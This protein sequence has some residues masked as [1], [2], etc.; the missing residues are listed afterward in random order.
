MLSTLALHRNSWFT[1]LLLTCAAFSGAAAL[2]YQVVW[3]RQFLLLFG[4]TTAATAAVIAA[5]MGGMALGAFWLGRY[6][7]RLS[8]PLL[9]YAGLE[10][11]VALYALIF[12]GLLTKAELLYGSV[13]QLVENHP[14]LIN[15]LRL[16]FGLVMLLPPTIALGA[17][18]PLLV[19]IL[20]ARRARPNASGRLDLWDQCWWRCVWSFYRRIIPHSSRGSH[21][22]LS[23]RYWTQLDS[24]YSG[25]GAMAMARNAEIRNAKST[26]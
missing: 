20:A 23:N 19:R 11:A 14:L 16:G 24:S 13:W 22:N 21:R 12:P 9:V 10:I 26:P 4:S 8:A 6:A 7:Y 2:V 5:F 3:N 15:G 18:L 1:R 25:C 17:T